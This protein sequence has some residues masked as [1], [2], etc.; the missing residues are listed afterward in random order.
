[1]WLGQIVSQFGDRLTQIA[2]VGLVSKAT[3]SS[4]SLAVVMSLAI[5]PVFLISPVSGVYIDRWSKRKTMYASD[6]LRGI[7]ILAIPF[8]LLKTR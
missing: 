4:S 1:M 2:L 3:M 5:I 8:L 6:A 7:L